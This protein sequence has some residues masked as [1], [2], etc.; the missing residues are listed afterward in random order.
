M[1]MMVRTGL[2]A[3]ATALASGCSSGDGDLTLFSVRNGDE[4]SI[5]PIQQDGVI[6]Y[7]VDTSCYGWLLQFEPV[8]GTVEIEEV[9]T[10]PAK[11]EHWG[12]ADRSVV[13]GDGT[14]ARTVVKVDG[15]Q[16][17]AQHSWC[18]AEGDPEGTY[19]FAI[20]RD[21]REVGELR[22]KLQRS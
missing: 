18:V 5:V 2:L 10:I 14:S 22:F 21:G 6:A 15:R 1:H 11:A 19:S 3:L 16:G 4:S 12:T 17:S 13:S 7:R 8:A 9:L 20:S